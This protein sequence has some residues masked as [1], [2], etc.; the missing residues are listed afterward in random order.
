MTIAL[1]LRLSKE[2]GDFG[3]ESNSITNQR[4]LLNQYIS[5]FTKLRQMKKCE[6]IDDGYSGKN[7]CRPGMLRLLHDSQAGNIHCIIVKDFSRFGRNHIMV[8]NYIEKVLPQLNIRF[9]SVNNHFDSNNYIGITPEMDVAFE[10]LMYDYFSEENSIKI[11]NDLL[12]KRMRG[13]YMAVF[14][15]FGYKKS[16]A[17]HC[18][19]AIDAKAAKIVKK[20]FELYT[21][22]GSKAEVARNLNRHNIPTPQTY[23]VMHGLNYSWRYQTDKKYWNSAMISRILKNPVYIGNTVFHKKEVVAT[24]SSQTKYLPKDR[25]M[26]CENTHEAIISKDLYDLVNSTKDYSKNNSAKEQQ[27]KKANCAAAITGLVK[28]GGCKH[29]MVRRNRLKASFY[30]RYYYAEKLDDCCFQNVSEEHLTKV[31]A[32]IIFLHDQIMT[33]YHR[34]SSF[35]SNLEKQLKNQ[36]RD[37]T[38][39]MIGMNAQCFDL[40]EHYKHDE[41]TFEQYTQIKDKKVPLTIYYQNQLQQ[42]EAKLNFSFDQPNVTLN[43][44]VQQLFVYHRNQI[45][46]VLTY[47]DEIIPP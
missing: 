42:L 23:M 13:D 9:I 2:D 28:C 8:G 33:D 3:D 15:P 24:G 1:Y 12:K 4:Y 35:Q 47:E 20:V 11:K 39:K 5:G 45:K 27:R 29:N 30:C 34:L 44:L 40:Y 32:Q 37:I 14:A 18:Q 25:W 38:K 10:N 46:I 16:A 43:K 19:L 6:Y 31:L 41:I 17:N 36:I 22:V 26:V 21:E 7:F